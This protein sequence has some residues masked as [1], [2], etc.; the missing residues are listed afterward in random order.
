M[1]LCCDVSHLS[2]LQS[3]SVETKSE[4]KLVTS[5]I[6]VVRSGVLKHFDATGLMLVGGGML[7]SS[8]PMFTT[9]AL[10]GTLPGASAYQSDTGR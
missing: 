4:T 7:A 5:V 3:A 1:V 2:F 9:A 6:A 8:F 10:T